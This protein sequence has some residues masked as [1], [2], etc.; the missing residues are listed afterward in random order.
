MIPALERRLRDNPGLSGLMARRIGDLARIP[1][2][3]AASLRLHAIVCGYG[4]VG[5]LLGRAFERRG[6]RY[7]VITQR[8]D[9]VD[10]LRGQGVTAIYGDAGDPGRARAWRGSPTRGSW[11]S[12]H[13]EPGATRL[14]DRARPRHEPCGRHGGAHAQRHRSWPTCARSAARCKS[15]TRSVSWPC[16]WR[17]TGCAGSG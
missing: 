3:E 6:F 11:S 16:R 13:P 10:R 2:D 17:V 1:P 15:C 4:R 7:V 8:R 9:E 14:I 5:R 12:R